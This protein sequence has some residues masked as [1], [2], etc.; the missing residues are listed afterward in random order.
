MRPRGVRFL[1]RAQ[2]CEI[3]RGLQNKGFLR[4]ENTTPLIQRTKVN[5]SPR[6]HSAEFLLQDIVSLVRTRTSL[7]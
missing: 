2:A 7:V 3:D 4:V 1:P 6:D 5:Q